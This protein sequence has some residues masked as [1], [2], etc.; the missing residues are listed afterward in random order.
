[1]PYRAME[2]YLIRHTTPE[3]DPGIC[4]G[5]SD[6][7]VKH[8]FPEE[9]KSLRAH[10]PE[11]L[12]KVYSSP[13]SR[14]QNLASELS[15]TLITDR[16]LMEMDFGHWELR[17][18]DEIPAGEMNTWMK[19]FVTV[20]PPG[21]ENFS[22]LYE[23]A[24][25]FFD[26]QLKQ[27]QE[28]IAIVCHAGVIRAILAKVLEIPLKNAFKMPVSYASVTRLNLHSESCFCSIGFLNRT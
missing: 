1:M 20:K 4:Y 12:D 7:A 14:C 19:D 11:K 18:W 13:L 8:T 9:L 23:R 6:V 2:I 3:I 21:G 5:Q 27:D 22:M 10:L 25:Q 26:E 17:R 16:R 24:G 15:G 28:R